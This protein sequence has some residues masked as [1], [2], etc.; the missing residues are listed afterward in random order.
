M[1]KSYCAKLLIE[2]GAEVNFRDFW[3][4]SLL[5][6]AVRTNDCDCLKTL[7]ATRA[8]TNHPDEHGN[9]ALMLAIS[10]GKTDCAKLLI[11]AGADV[12]QPD[13]HGRTAL[14]LAS[15]DGNSDC[16]KLLIEAGADVNQVDKQGDTPLARATTEGRFDLAK[17]L[18]Q[19][20]AEI[21]HS[22]AGTARMF[23]LA[24]LLGD[25]QCVL[26]LL[27]AG[28]DINQCY[29]PHEHYLFRAA[30]NDASPAHYRVT[31]AIRDDDRNF[32]KI[33]LDEGHAVPS[34][35]QC[36]VVGD[37]AKFLALPLLLFVGGCQGVMLYYEGE[38]WK[39]FFPE[40]WDDPC[41][42]NQCRKFI[43][44]H[45]L[46]LKLDTNL[47]VPVRQLEMTKEKPGLPRKLVSYLLWDQS[48][49]F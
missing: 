32:L 38:R 35:V 36:K 28:V 37:E 9:T 47:F 6:L 23:R 14:M 26:R 3:G 39:R 2:A 22:S 19:A 13:E 42:K 46:T 43:R 41:L 15:F 34:V 25:W 12:N 48:S 16:T 40:D 10:L 24:V 7:L 18:L 33:L 21:Y 49:D 11:E 17:I 44:K 45:L 29:R 30:I 31:H 4:Q 27:D 20:G 1:E 8:D 5:S